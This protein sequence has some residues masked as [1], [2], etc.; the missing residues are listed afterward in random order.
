MAC[1]LSLSACTLQ[2]PSKD[3]AAPQGALEPWLRI[4]VIEEEYIVYYKSKKKKKNIGVIVTSGS[5]V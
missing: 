1:L 4:S 5:I 2:N 3:L